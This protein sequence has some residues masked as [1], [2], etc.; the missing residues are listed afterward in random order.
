MAIAERQAQ[1]TWEGS[2]TKGTG[3]ITGSSGALDALAV[4]W[5]SR[6]E[7]S[8]GQTS[9]EELIAAAHSSCFAM[10]LSHELREGGHEPVR[11]DVTAV[12]TLDM[13]DDAPT[14]TRSALTVSGS[15]EGIDA[16]GFE[17]AAQSAGKNCPISRLL[18]GSAEIAVDA[19]FAG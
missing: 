7:R 10:A 15:A 4:T 16:A 5:A 2:L 17:A 9:P 3:R 1:T 14:V 8:N 13:V 18:G 6:T 12:V 11:L 19:T